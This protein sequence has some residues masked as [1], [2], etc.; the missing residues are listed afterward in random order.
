MALKVP[1]ADG[2]DVVCTIGRVNFTDTDGLQPHVAA[3]Q[4]IAEHDAPGSY[5]FPMADGRSCIVNV[6]HRVND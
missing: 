6:E 4:L 3:F 2:F 5:S 1:V